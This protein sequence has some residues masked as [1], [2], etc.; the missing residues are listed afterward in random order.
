MTAYPYGPGDVYPEN[1]DFKDYMSTY[2]TRKIETESFK[3][4]LRQT[5]K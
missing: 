2:N 1:K 5:S 4:F 3:Q